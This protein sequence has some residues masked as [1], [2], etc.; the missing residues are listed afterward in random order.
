MMRKRRREGQEWGRHPVHCP[1]RSLREQDRREA[2]LTPAHCTELEQV[3]ADVDVVD[4][5]K[6][7]VEIE[8]FDGRPGEAAEQSEVQDGSHC[9]AR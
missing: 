5:P 4:A 8:A 3:S 9:C 2:L 1:A 6:E 7:Q